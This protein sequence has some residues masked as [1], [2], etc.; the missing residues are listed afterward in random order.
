MNITIVDPGNFF[1]GVVFTLGIIILF[2]DLIPR[3]RKRSKHKWM[4]GIPTRKMWEEPCIIM[5]DPRYDSGNSMCMQRYY[6][7]DKFDEHTSCFV[8]QKWDP[9]KNIWET[10][11]SY[12]ITHET[13]FKYL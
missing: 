12:P 9:D 2:W 8:K 10:T 7:V 1:G 5:I 6:I 11:Q 3:W 13:Y 4:Q